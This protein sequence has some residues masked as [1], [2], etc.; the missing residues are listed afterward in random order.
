MGQSLGQQD[1]TVGD[2]CLLPKLL[3]V[4]S[5]SF[6]SRSPSTLYPHKTSSDCVNAQTLAFAVPLDTSAL[7]GQPRAAVRPAA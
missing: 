2:P 7:Q 5:S 6:S 4:K 1:G 3:P